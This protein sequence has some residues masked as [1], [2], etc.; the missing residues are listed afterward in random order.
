MAATMI[1][2]GKNPMTMSYGERGKVFAGGM[3]AR[4][5]GGVCRWN[6]ATS[7]ELG[8][9]FGATSFELPSHWYKMGFQKQ[10]E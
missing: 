6:G 4:Q 3:D 7:F 1:I 8:L 10:T 2:S 5:R 9:G